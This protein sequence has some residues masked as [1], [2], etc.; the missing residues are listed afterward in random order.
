[1]WIF[2]NGLSEKQKRNTPRH[3]LGIGS[4]TLSLFLRSFRICEGSFCVPWNERV[5][6]LLAQDSGSV[7]SLA[8][9]VPL[10]SLQWPG[11]CSSS[12]SEQ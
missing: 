4:S 10:R 12:G 9:G 3:H 7:H 5:A 8:G 6:A 2:L 11:T 1:M